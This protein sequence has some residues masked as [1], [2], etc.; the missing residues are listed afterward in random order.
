MQTVLWVIYD[1]P[2][3]FPA[4]PRF[5]AR[6]QW[7]NQAGQICFDPNAVVSPSLEK[8]REH[9]RGRGHNVCLGR[10]PNDQPHIVE[11]WL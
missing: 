7:A 5:V 2:L 4:G 11:V 1:R 10:Q 9:V 6:R 8:L 3:D